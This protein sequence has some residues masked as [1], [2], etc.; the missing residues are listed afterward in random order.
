MQKFKEAAIALLLGL[1]GCNFY[2]LLSQ[3]LFEID[4]LRN[5]HGWIDGMPIAYQYFASILHFAASDCLVVFF[6]VTM[7]GILLGLIVPRNPLVYGILASIGFSVFLLVS[8]SFGIASLF[9]ALFRAVL[10]CVLVVLAA[11]TGM[12]IRTRCRPSRAE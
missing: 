5:Y 12:R 2:I 6:T 4:L 9:I 3:W 1:V 11:S 10:W 7:T 8:S